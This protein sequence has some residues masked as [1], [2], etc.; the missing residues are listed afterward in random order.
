MS[1]VTNTIVTV[2]KHQWPCE[3]AVV[4]AN[5]AKF[6]LYPSRFSFSWSGENLREDTD[7][8]G[9]QWFEEKAF[10]LDLSDGEK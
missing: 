8:N 9:S 6:G 7:A 1:V 4:L 10:V 3:S 2:L 5:N